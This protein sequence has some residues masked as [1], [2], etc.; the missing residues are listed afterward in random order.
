MDNHAP[1]RQASHARPAI[2]PDGQPSIAA[3]WLCS[4][5][6]RA[7]PAASSRAGAAGGIEQA[8]G[9]NNVRCRLSEVQQCFSGPPR[10]GATAA[11]GLR[12]ILHCELDGKPYHWEDCWHLR[13]RCNVA[14]GGWGPLAY[15]C[16]L[17]SN[18]AQNC[19]YVSLGS[20][21]SRTA[22]GWRAE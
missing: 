15:S 1:R 3:I 11:R 13:W 6:R 10:G 8:V 20:S 4:A 5:W 17:V 16:I 2:E 7:A 22:T 9:R 12:S 14:A 19:G 21:M 18:Q